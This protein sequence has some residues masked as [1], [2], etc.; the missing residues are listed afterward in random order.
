SAS[1]R[2][3][4]LNAASVTITVERVRTNSPCA[5]VTLLG[6]GMTA[7][8]KDNA[9]SPMSGAAKISEPRTNRIRVEHLIVSKRRRLC[10]KKNYSHRGAWS[11]QAG[12]TQFEELCQRFDPST[13]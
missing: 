7:T 1:C 3:C 11:E 4:A 5:S 9:G 6:N 10:P 2:A 12:F 13:G 8:G